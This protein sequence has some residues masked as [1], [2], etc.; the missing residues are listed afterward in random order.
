MTH[1]S[2]APAD[3]VGVLRA[4]DAVHFG[5]G[6]LASLTPA[7][8]R[9]GSRALVVVD[10]FLSGTP[11]FAGALAALDAAGVSVHV[12]SE[13]VPELP[14]ES[15][16]AATE[17]A[18]AVA[19][20][21]V[22]AYGGGSALDLGKLVALLLSQPGPL[23]DYYGE[24]KV[25]GPVLPIVAV[26]TTAGTGSEATPVAVVSDP[27][28]ELKVG[29]SDAALIPRVAIVDPDLTMGAPAPV[30]AYS[31]IDAIVHCAESFTAIDRSP[32]WSTQ[33]PIFVGRNRMSSL[34]GLD[35]LRA[36]GDALPR[37]VKDGSDVEARER[38]AWGSLLGGM[39][40]GSGGTHLSHALQYPIGALTH[41]PHGLGTGLMLPYVLQ[42]CFDLTVDRLALMADALG[43]AR[44]TSDRDDA[45]AAIDRL[46]AINAEI[47]LPSSLA[48]LGLQRAQLPRIA[49]L[50]AGVTRLVA[51]ASREATPALL[52][53]ILDAAYDGDRSRLA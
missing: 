44:A 53:R 23:S 28:R 20:D 38:M 4:P 45:Q 19:P 10:P 15:V 47:G 14:V 21:V 7:V 27:E 17:A 5:R 9:L 31:G 25:T 2:H 16:V 30:T 12:H 11:A 24:N 29:V 35:G 43:V 52:E 22:V 33:L 18:R 41:T 3:P 40:F 8:A 32:D 49:E 39:A 37:A 13:V 6:A 46:A 1:H 36:M 42:V 50:A 26:P 48:D 51:L 34:L